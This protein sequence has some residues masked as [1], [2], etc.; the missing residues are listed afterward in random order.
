MELIAYTTHHTTRFAHAGE[1][2]S[3]NVVV[4]SRARR[5]NE[6][7]LGISETT[8]NGGCYQ[9]ESVMV[10]WAMCDIEGH[11]VHFSVWHSP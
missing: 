5:R 10:V 3:R 6:R 8:Q 2:L 4:L 1:A 7:S 11:G 9:V